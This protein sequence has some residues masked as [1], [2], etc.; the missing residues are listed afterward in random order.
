MQQKPSCTVYQRHS[1][2]HLSPQGVHRARIP[3]EQPDFRVRG[4]SSSSRFIQVKQ[5]S[6][7]QQTHLPSLELCC[8]TTECGHWRH[9]RCRY[10][11]HR[12]ACRYI[13]LASTRIELYSI[14]NTILGHPQMPI[15]LQPTEERDAF[16][17]ILVHAGTEYQTFCYRAHPSIDMLSHAE[18]H[19]RVTVY[20]SDAKSKLQS[21]CK[22]FFKFT[23]FILFSLTHT[24][25]DMHSPCR[26][27]RLCDCLSI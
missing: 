23:G 4:L 3:T 22:N 25:I 8:R 15:A 19:Y 21:V 11:P 13:L 16:Y 7:S 27:P 10:Q 9:S 14:H 1:R 26:I 12:Y 17:S 20:Q 2:S 18:Y 6:Q 24:S 5:I